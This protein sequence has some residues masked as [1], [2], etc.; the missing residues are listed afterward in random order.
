MTGKK[1]N[2]IDLAKYK[3]NSKKGLIV[4]VDLEYPQ[5]LHSLHNDLPVAPEKAKYP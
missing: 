1:I 2:K 4:D 5:Q 3:K